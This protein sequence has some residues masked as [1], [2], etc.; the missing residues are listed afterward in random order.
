MKRLKVAVAVVTVSAGCSAGSPS[1]PASSSPPSQQPPPQQSTVSLTGQ[2]QGQG[3]GPIVRATVTILDGPDTGRSMMTGD[4]GLYRFDNLTRSNANLSATASNYLEVRS[5]TFINGTNTLNFTLPRADRW[6]R[7]GVGA[8][9]FTMPSYI[10]KVNLTADFAG[11]CQYFQVRFQTG[12]IVNT[13]LGDCTTHHLEGTF[14]A[15]VRG[16]GPVQVINFTDLAGGHTEPGS[17][18]WTLVEVP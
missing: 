4:G 7:S 10:E 2:V 15:H 16:G 9:M 3:T 8:Q 14:S 5:G 11:S 18:A 1:S 17:V 12:W 6:S 13:N